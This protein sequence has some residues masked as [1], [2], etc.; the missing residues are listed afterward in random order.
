MSNLKRFFNVSARNSPITHRFF[1][2]SLVEG[3]LT[4]CGIRMQKG[5]RYWLAVAHVHRRC[6]RCDSAT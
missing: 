5:W 2:K 6:K 1:G 4:Q 3:E